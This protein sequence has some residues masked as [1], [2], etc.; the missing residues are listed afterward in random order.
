MGALLVSNPIELESVVV[1]AAAPL[2]TLRGCFRVKSGELSDVLEAMPPSNVSN[3][4]MVEM[5][6]VRFDLT[7]SAGSKVHKSSLE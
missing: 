1:L 7:F 6:S 5:G 4:L 3:G 2:L